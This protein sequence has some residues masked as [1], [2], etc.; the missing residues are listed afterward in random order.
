MAIGVDF[1]GT[2]IEAVYLDEAGQERVR[3][4]VPTPRHDYEGSVR[5][6]AALIARVESE[7]GAPEAPVGIGI[8]GSVAPDTGL[9]R[10]GNTVWTI[11]RPFDRD[12]ATAIGRPVR[13]EN[14]ANCFALSEATDGAGAGA[15]SVFGVIL[16][17]GVGGGLVIGGR[18]VGG[19]RGVAGEWGHIPLVA[20]EPDELGGPVCFCGRQG[21][22]EVWLS[23]PGLEADFA[24]SVGV[25]E[26]PGAAE[27]AALAAEGDPEAQAA[28]D[29]HARRLARMLGVV[30]NIVDPEVI[31]MGGGLSN[32][33]HLYRDLPDLVR[34]HVLAEGAEVTIRPARHGDSS[35]VRGAARLWE[36]S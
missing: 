11:G 32:M 1:G 3:I 22:L 4:R 8:P 7:A 25:G 35:G 9:V 26:G 12:I 23:G 29:R 5:A 27:I 36:A 2:K 14:D 34:P 30:I 18:L 19:A 24:R 16:G 13:M 21:C 15:G 31:V 28:L 6:V 20:T 17:T 10:N 33:A